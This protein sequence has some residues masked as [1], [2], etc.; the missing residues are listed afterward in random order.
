MDREAAVIR[1]EMS[2]TRAELD[3]KISRL[4]A[5]A[6]E[7]T[8]GELTRRYVPEYFVDR[9]IGGFLTMIGLSLAWSMRR[10]RV[11][12]RESIRAAMGGYS[13]WQ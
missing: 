2:H 3:R 4:E 12:R 1:A 10:R 11:H 9:A 6:K 13:G 5:R 7:F 8:P